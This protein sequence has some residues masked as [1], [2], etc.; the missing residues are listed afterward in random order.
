[1]EQN[2]ISLQYGIRRTPSLGE[3][4][5]LSEC[6]NLIPQSGELVNIPTP[7]DLG[8]AM[9]ENEELL[10]IHETPQNSNNYIVLEGVSESGS[11]RRR[12][13]KEG[14]L[15]LNVIAQCLDTGFV[16]TTSSNVGD[17]EDYVYTAQV[18]FDDGQ[19]CEVVV[20][21][22]IKTFSIA[23]TDGKYSTDN[24]IKEIT[25]LSPESVI[26]NGVTRTVQFETQIIRY[27]EPA[28]EPEPYGGEYSL[29]YF[30][31]LDETRERKTIIA[32]IENVNSVK[33]LGNMLVVFT[34]K[35]TIFCLWN[36]KDYEV[37]GS[38]LPELPISFG[39][40]TTLVEA[41]NTINLN[42]DAWLNALIYTY[43]AQDDSSHE[44]EDIYFGDDPS[45]ADGDRYPFGH[46]YDNRVSGEK[47]NN[48]KRVA[49]DG[50]MTAL[51]PM[52]QSIKEAEKFALPFMVRYAYRMYDDS[53]VMASAPILMTPYTIPTCRVTSVGESGGWVISMR[54][55]VSALS[56]TLDYA[57]TSEDRVAELNKWKS[58]IQSV[59]IFV[60]SPMYFYDPS[61]DT[62]H[63]VRSEN[64]EYE[65]KYAADTLAGVPRVTISKYTAPT[66]ATGVA[67]QQEYYDF[68]QGLDPDGKDE[69]PAVAFVLS[70]K[71]KDEI[72]KIITQESLFY[73]V[74][75]IKLSDLSSER[76]EVPIENGA[77]VGLEAREQLTE[78]FREHDEYI[79]KDGFR[80]NNRLF[81]YSPK[82]KSGL[83]NLD[84]SS[85]IAYTNRPVIPTGRTEPTQGGSLSTLNLLYSFAKTPPN[86]RGIQQI[87]TGDDEK[88]WISGIEDTNISYAGLTDMNNG[89]AIPFLFLPDDEVTRMCLSVDSITPGSYQ[90]DATPHKFLNGSYIYSGYTALADLI[91]QSVSK[92]VPA[93]ITNEAPM[94]NELNKIFLSDVENPFV[95]SARNTITLDVSDII[96]L[97]TTA[98]ALSQGQFGQFPMYAFTTDGIWALEISAEGKV[99]ARQPVSRDVCTNPLSIT[100]LD[101]SV[102]FVTDQGLK[103]ISGSNVELLSGSIDGYNIS[104]TFFQ[105]ALTKFCVKAEEDVPLIVDTQ[106]FVEQVQEAQIVYDYAN[107]LLHIFPDGMHDNNFQKH[108]VLS[109]DTREWSTQLIRERLITSVPTYPLSTLQMVQNDD[110]TEISL[111]SYKKVV[112]NEAKIGYALTRPLSLGDPL[113]RKALYDLRVVGQRVTSDALRRVAVY[114][115][116]DNIHWYQLKSLKA[117]S[118]K[119]Y[120]FLVMSKQPDLNTLSGLSVQYDYRYNHK[121]RGH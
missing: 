30:S 116:N 97:A 118:A 47:I 39:L 114:V 70:Q 58:L 29:K 93:E 50:I 20:D 119:Y 34:D 41:E 28:P 96:G 4:G 79:F 9:N 113:T 75:S 2:N 109:L 87:P 24:Q 62:V 10:Y 56:G 88:T 80:Y 92:P 106:Q 40:Q 57:V 60:S 112:S 115:S 32:D 104:E 95:L 26:I 99:S 107:N 66:G 54:I 110:N 61:G 76:T 19:T 111:Y 51:N 78:N 63:L 49:T 21:T 64:P 23:D 84:L 48:L 25:L 103:I 33:S 69:I 53:L 90:K 105:P 89:T 37:L 86:S 85:L 44:V 45:Y 15:F 91:D 17:P 6:V 65:K 22:Y 1:M 3:D 117:L 43:L 59:D 55:K 121:M 67:R 13:A 18:T 81:L 94:F 101:G 74:A 31:D 83:N 72:E 100:Q 108:Y 14:I 77:L 38:H 35:A 98:T 68:S 46:I 73:K 16:F 8:I 42:E 71:S 102:V 5:E 27:N 82:R 120:R 52:L 11:R 36:N 12:K 7:S